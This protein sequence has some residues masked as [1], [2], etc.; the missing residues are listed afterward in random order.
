[1]D[2]LIIAGYLLIAALILQVI[3]RNFDEI[4]KDVPIMLP[5]QL[6]LVRAIVYVMVVF[7]PVSVV[8]APFMNK[9]K[10]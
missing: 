8:M 9:D 5:I 1:M 6:Y 10:T 3:E 7:W 2:L 4:T